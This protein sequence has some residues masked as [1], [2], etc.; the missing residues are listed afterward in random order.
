VER[1]DQQEQAE[2]A[3]HQDQQELVVHQA[4]QE[5]LD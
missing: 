3:E 2:Q 1:Q 4:L 5:H